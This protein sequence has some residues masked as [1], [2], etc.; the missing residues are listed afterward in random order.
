MSYL[1]NWSTSHEVRITSLDFEDL[2][3]EQIFIR[4]E[5]K[6]QQGYNKGQT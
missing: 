2:I 6:E 1:P 3:P 4:E 5:W